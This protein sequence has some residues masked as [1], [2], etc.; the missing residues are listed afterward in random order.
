MASKYFGDGGLAVGNVDVF[1]MI[2]FACPD[3]AQLRR[4]VRE[5]TCFKRIFT[6]RKRDDNKTRLELHEGTNNLPKPVDEVVPSLDSVK[7]G[8]QSDLNIGL[9]LPGE[10]LLN[11]YFFV[12]G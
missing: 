7:V 3:A 11:T 8:R 6:I 2:G 9:I 5:W 1:L 12:K 4:F 10:F